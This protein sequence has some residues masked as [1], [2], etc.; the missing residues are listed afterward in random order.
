MKEQE[1]EV[2]LEQEQINESTSLVIYN[3]DINSFDY[4]IYLL[5]D[6]CKLDSV[7]A[8]QCT[9]IAHHKGK[10]AVKKGDADEMEV[11]MDQLERRGLGASVE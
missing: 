4:V 3:D 2:V 9:I 6:V 1:L 11:L 7:R 10:C 8:E 5:E